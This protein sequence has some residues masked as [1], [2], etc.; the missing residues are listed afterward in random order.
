MSALHP[1]TGIPLADDLPSSLNMNPDSGQGS[2]S[3]SPHSLAHI[4]PAI[5]NRIRHLDLG[6]RVT[7]KD[8][9]P[10]SGGA[11]GDVYKLQCDIPQHGILTVA[12]KRFRLYRK[13]D[14]KIVSLQSGYNIASDQRHFSYSNKKYMCGRN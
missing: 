4:D 5:L 12:V 6:E 9:Y 13:D 14:I 7:L 11:Y 3:A 8:K 10:I 2:S 1:L